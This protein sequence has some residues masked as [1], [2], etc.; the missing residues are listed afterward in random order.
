MTNEYGPNGW[1][2][3]M[4]E[5][6]AEMVATQ[7]ERAEANRVNRMTTPHERREEEIEGLDSHRGRT[8]LHVKH[9]VHSEDMSNGNWSK[10]ALQSSESY[11]GSHYVGIGTTVCPVSAESIFDCPI[12]T[13]Q[14]PA[15]GE[16]KP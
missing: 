6:D 4:E 10:R 1:Y 7:V 14:H 9:G 5:R 3:L 15:P 13:C 11:R 12:P 8:A 2:A 16:V